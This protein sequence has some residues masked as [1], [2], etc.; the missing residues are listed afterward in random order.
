MSRNL[1]RRFADDERGTA[2]IMAGF[3]VIPIFGMMALAVDYT[4]AVRVETQIN[5]AAQSV[6]LHLAKRTTLNPNI[7]SEQLIDEGKALM[8]R[9]VK[10]RDITYEHFNVDTQD[11][12]VQIV[13]RTDVD[14]Y[15]MHLFGHD[16]LTVAGQKQ[17]QFGRR[18]VE[19]AIAIDN[20]GSMDF[21]SGSKRRIDAAKDATKVLMDAASEAM[22]DFENANLRFS[23]VP[24]HTNVTVPPEYRQDN[25]GNDA[26]WIDWEGRS[27]GHFNYLAP[28]DRSNG[29]MYYSMP[30][31][32]NSGHTSD[33]WHYYVPEL[34]VNYLP[35]EPDGD[36]IDI[37]A[38]RNRPNIGI[39]TR[40]DVF[41]RFTNVEWAGC[42]EH[43]HGDYQFSF[44]EP[45]M[46]DGDSLFVPYMAP[47]EWDTWGYNSYISDTGG[48]TG[49]PGQ[50][51][52]GGNDRWRQEIQRM[53]NTP[54]YAGSPGPTSG[55]GAGP[56]GVCN[57]APLIAMSEDRNA[58]EDAVEEMQAN[59]GT[60]LSIGLEWAMHTLTPW[61]PLD[62]A[63]EFG[64][65]EKILVFMTDGDNFPVAYPDQYRNSYTSF[66]Y[67]KDDMSNY[68][69]P[70][71]PNRTHVSRALDEASKRYCTAIKNLGVRIYFVYFG[72]PS[73]AATGIMNHCASS[74]E[75]AISAS[76]SQE[77]EDA[78]RKIG[79][80]IGKLRLS[81]Y[82]P[83]DS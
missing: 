38:L 53:A 77:L 39:I 35:K 67:A 17:A 59:G 75:T 11:G 52:G 50:I 58:I 64:K 6:A 51:T 15:F 30:R 46:S 23:L 70:E 69:M 25:S 62:Q 80:D 16:E 74:P 60:D 68:G 81:H 47:D 72:D 9:M 3:A 49:S 36:G 63:A 73:A 1:L 57:T 5:T 2:Y 24:W 61:E 4:N 12:M 14:T 56:N 44:D 79:D 42:F 18:D 83:P 82:T 27:T 8:A 41:D 76:N 71:R 65:A 28:Y 48:E 40:R 13:A 22:D 33:E 7:S 54:K 10:G 20:S 29:R 78:F 19:V 55:N 45:T 37:D 31:N 21:W 32:G 34:L 26:W 66:Q 43:R